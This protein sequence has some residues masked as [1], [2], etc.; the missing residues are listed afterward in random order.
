MD[1]PDLALGAFVLLVV[2]WAIALLSLPLAHR[3]RA[4]C[5]RLATSLRTDSRY[6]DRDPSPI[7]HALDQNV[8]NIMAFA[9]PIILPVTILALA[10]SG[11]VMHLRRSPRF[12]PLEGLEWARFREHELLLLDDEVRGRGTL[13]TDP[14]FRRLGELAF[15]CEIANRPLVS[16]ITVVISLPSLLLY[17]AVYGAREAVLILPQLAYFY[18]HALRPLVRPG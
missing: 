11:L 14:R 4:R 16:L 9:F 12:S 5:D 8:G 6:R 10:G 15:E 3:Y 18:A 1:L 17:G 2:A 7:V 13:R